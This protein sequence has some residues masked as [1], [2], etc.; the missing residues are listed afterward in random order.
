[1]PYETYRWE[2]TVGVRRGFPSELGFGLD[3]KDELQP[4][5]MWRCELQ[6]AENCKEKRLE[7]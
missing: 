7:G 4:D 2:T 3:S 1:M 6:T 5:V